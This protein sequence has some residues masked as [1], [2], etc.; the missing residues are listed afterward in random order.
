MKKAAVIG[1]FGF[2]HAYFDGQ[3][4]KTKIVTEALSGE[5]GDESI[6]RFD[7]HGGAK[8][9]LKAPLFVLSALAKAQNVIILPAHNGLRVFGRM[10]PLFK[11]FFK[12][13][14]LHYVVIGGWLPKKLQEDTDLA[15]A[16][17]RFDAIY[18]ETNTVKNALEAQG[19]T[20]IRVMPNCKALTPLQPK[21]FVYQ[22][23]PPYKLCTFSRVMEEKG[24]GDAVAAVK[25]VNEQA[26][27]TLYTLDIYGQIDPGQTQWFQQMQEEFPAYVRYGGIVPFQHSVEVLK[28]YFALLFPTRYFT[29]GVP[30]TI[31][32]AYA[33][34]VPVVSAKWE[35][36]GD[37]VDDGVTG[38][39]YDFGSQEALE[40]TLLAIGEN[41]E[42]LNGLKEACLE[43]SKCFLPKTA[44][45][46]IIQELA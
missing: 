7:T 12:G 36:F 42:A 29:E 26:G 23:Q 19:F 20:N 14:K 16:L 28:D 43:K 21:D 3:T 38:I 39:G 4:V 10:L 34:G 37:I 32:D 11:G 40:K 6:L 1:H 30:G 41:P 25:A 15:R 8:T 27:K 46:T 2:G 44:I 5:Y 45:Q 9:L 18:A 17:K 35:S 31:I 24:I 33:S 13:R 22:T